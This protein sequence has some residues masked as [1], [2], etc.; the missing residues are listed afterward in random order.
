[1]PVLAKIFKY[2]D[3]EYN[4]QILLKRSTVQSGT[5][6]LVIQQT[7]LERL[8]AEM[9]ARPVDTTGAAYVVDSGAMTEYMIATGVYPMVIAATHNIKNL[10]TDDELATPIPDTEGLMRKTLNSSISVKDFM[11]LPEALVFGWQNAVYEVNPHWRPVNPSEQTEEEKTVGE[12][13]APN[14]NSGLTSNSSVG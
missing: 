14:D 1:M 5:R 3:E 10:W 6:R 13:D 8:Q 4:V 7:E 9:H 2:Q 12:D 11:E